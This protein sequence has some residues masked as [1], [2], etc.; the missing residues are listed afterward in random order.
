MLEKYSSYLWIR[1]FLPEKEGI[2]FIVSWYTWATQMLFRGRVAL[3]VND[4][5]AYRHLT[6]HKMIYLAAYRGEGLDSR[7]LQSRHHSNCSPSQSPELAQTIWTYRRLKKFCPFLYSDSLGIYKWTRR[8][9]HLVYY[10][11]S[12]S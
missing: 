6:Y 1:V 4:R 12:M 5:P 10:H 3:N 9:G 2:F 8:L 7:P 11:I